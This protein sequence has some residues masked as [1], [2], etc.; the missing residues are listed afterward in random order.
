LRTE[1]LRRGA[2]RPWPW[3]AEGFIGF[4]DVEAAGAGVTGQV[5]II[6][7]RFVAEQGQT[8]A[9]L[10][11]ERTVARASVTALPAEQAHHVTL[12]IHFFDGFIARQFD[13]ARSD[14]GTDQG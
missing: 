4:A 14:G 12:E 3:K 6:H 9:A 8:E 11:L 7:L 2:L 10:A 5:V 13:R 1:S